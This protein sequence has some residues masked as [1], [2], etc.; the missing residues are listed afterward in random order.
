MAALL[1]DATGDRAAGSSWE[2]ALGLETQ[3]PCGLRVRCVCDTWKG[4]RM[5]CTIDL[6]GRREC[7]SR[8]RRLLQ[9]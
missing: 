3:Q 7:A 4:S 9:V 2:G 5:S 6:E 1:L 8:S